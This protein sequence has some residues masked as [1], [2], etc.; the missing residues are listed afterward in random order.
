M[1]GEHEAV[2]AGDVDIF[3]F[4][5]ADNR[6]EQ[7]AALAHQ[8]Q[9]VAIAQSATFPPDRLAGFD[10]PPYR[11]GDSP[12]QPDPRT[13]LADLIEWRIPAVDLGAFFRFDR[14]PDFDQTGRRVRKRNMWGKSVGVGR[15]A[16]CNGVTTE[17]GIDRGQD[18]GSG[19]ERMLELAKYE[20][21]PASSMRA[22]EVT[23]HFGKFFRRRILE[24]ID[25][26]FLIADREH[27]PRRG[28]R[29]GADSKFGD[30]TAHDL[31]LLVAGVLRLVDQKMIDAEI[32]FVMNPGGVDIAEQPAGLVDQIVV[33]D[34]TAAVLLALIAPKDL[35]DDGEQ[36]GRAIPADHGA[37]PFQQCTDPR[38]FGC[39][40][41]GQA[42]IFDGLRNDRSPRGTL[43]RGT[44]NLEIGLDAVG[45]RQRGKLPKPPRLVAIALAALFKRG[46]N[47]RPVRCRNNRA[48]EKLVLDALATI[49]RFKPKLARHRRNRRFHA[50]AIGHPSGDRL[51]RGD[52]CPNRV[53]EALIG[54]GGDRRL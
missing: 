31:P 15:D 6:L 18:V 52:G 21:A 33:V 13:G 17:Y 36:R 7:F 22:L 48:S 4:Q 25:R 46:G 9:D 11:A 3:I 34:K 37:K 19:A 47:G 5:G 1:L 2:S 16:R 43:V 50:A 32:E 30:E 53:A 42:L 28:P 24:R 45:S 39:E 10:K 51:A 35:V 41:F 49:A 54:C 40:P 27:S 38:L 12:R 23:A 29:A 26:L 44:E 14:I 20:T 8:H